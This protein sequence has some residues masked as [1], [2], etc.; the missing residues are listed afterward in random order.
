M[1]RNRS[2]VSLSESTTERIELLKE[3]LEKVNGFK[4]SR[5][6]VVNYAVTL[7]EKTNLNEGAEA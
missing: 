1:I 2:C 6:Q 4:M 3:H 7:A 5:A